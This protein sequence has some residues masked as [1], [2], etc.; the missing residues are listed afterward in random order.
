MR[1]LF[2]NTRRLANSALIAKLAHEH[3][4]DVLILAEPGA[5]LAEI[6]TELNEGQ[7]VQFVPD[8]SPGLSD[9]LQ[10]FYRYRSESIRLVRDE[11]D[12]AVRHLNPPAQATLLLVAAHLPSKLYIT[13]EDQVLAAPPLARMIEA[14]EDLVGHRRTIVIGDLNM[15]PFEAGVVGAG[16]LHAVMDR[17][18]ALRMERILR[19]ERYRFF[20][21]PMWTT[22]GDREGSPPG[23][24]FYPA[25]GAVSYYWNTFDQVLVRPDLLHGLEPQ[26]DIQII[27]KANGTELIRGRF[28]RPD[29]R[30][31]DHLPILLNLALPETS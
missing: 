8:P 26:R 12:V 11:V 30:I 28:G 22:M 13:A 7:E 18:I 2:W 10:L 27:T 23:T 20:Y 1:I 6:L 17:R 15:N 5:K 24:Y 16:G 19:D 29:K 25:G 14:A 3:Q 21:N 9:R 31:S 4:T